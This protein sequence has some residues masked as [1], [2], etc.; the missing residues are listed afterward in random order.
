LSVALDTNVLVYAEGLNGPAKQEAALDLLAAL[1]PNSVF[2]PVQSLGELF[3]VLLRKANRT[4]SQAR[5]ALLTWR[6]AFPVIGTSETVIVAAADLAA[7]HRL[8]F[9][10]AVILASAAEGGCRLLLSED[11][12]PGF[13]WHGVTVAN[14]FAPSLHRLLGNLLRP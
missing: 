11:L 12:Q 14:P 10:D 6:D 8:G 9:W 4:A 5:G 2:V 1:P 7:T 3:Q 13:T